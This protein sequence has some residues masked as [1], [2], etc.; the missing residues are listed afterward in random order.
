MWIL[1]STTSL[2]KYMDSYE[3]YKR[4]TVV[5]RWSDTKV[6][7]DLVETTHLNKNIQVIPVTEMNCGSKQHNPLLAEAHD[8]EP[9]KMIITLGKR[10]GSAMLSSYFN[11]SYVSRKLMYSTFRDFLA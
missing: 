5:R 9:T 6:P 11:A 4:A 10:S 3:G 1:Y 7:D 2:K 8:S